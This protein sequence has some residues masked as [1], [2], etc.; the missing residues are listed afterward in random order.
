MPYTKDTYSIISF[1]QSARIG[2][3]N[4]ISVCFWKWVEAEN[5]C[6]RA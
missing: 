2:K 3:M 4:Q 1:M 5:D 6:D